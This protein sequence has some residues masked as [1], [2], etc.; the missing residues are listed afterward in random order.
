M[1]QPVKPAVSS[2]TPGGDD[3]SDE[4]FYLPDIKVTTN[5]QR[6]VSS[7]QFLI[8]KGRLELALD[9]HPG[10]HLGPLP[11]LNNA[12]ALE[13]QKEERETD[14]RAAL[15]EDVLS[16]AVGDE[17]RTKE[18]IRLM[19]AAT[20]RPNIDWQTKSLGSR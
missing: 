1:Q 10:L 12:V 4:I 13:M 11:K 17:A 16:I 7:F 8:A 5:K 19:R 18:L 20:A 9:A 2:A 3:P 15:L 6:P 14:R